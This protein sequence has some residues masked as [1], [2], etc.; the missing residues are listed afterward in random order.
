M[1]VRDFNRLADHPMVCRWW[2]AQKWPAIALDALP[3]T[4]LVGT[5]DDGVPLAAGWLYQTDSSIG[6]VEWIV[7]DPEADKE[8]RSE[9]LDLLIS[10]L[11]E[12]SLDLGIKALFTS[13]SNE[14]LIERYKKAGFQV[15]DTSMSN[16]IRTV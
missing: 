7:G 1:Q 2:H 9:A 11:V 14:R 13:C 15:T 16:L 8:Q 5:T 6:W 3:R 4:G 10:K 12:R